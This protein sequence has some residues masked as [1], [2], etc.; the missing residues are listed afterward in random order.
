M[1]FRSGFFGF[2]GFINNFNKFNVRVEDS[3][4]FHHILQNRGFLRIVGLIFGVQ[5]LMTYVGGTMFRTVALQPGEW[6]LITAMAAA[7]IPFDLMRKL[8]RNSRG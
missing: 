4:L 5:L 6:L 2:F 7:V 8:I 1:L 3:R